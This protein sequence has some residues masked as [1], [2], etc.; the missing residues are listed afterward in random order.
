[1]WPFRR[2]Q[3]PSPKRVAEL[4]AELDDVQVTLAWLR[5]SVK[6]LNGRLSTLQRQQR[7]AA[8]PTE[9]LDV[10]PEYHED[11]S[12]PSRYPVPRPVEPTAHLARRFRE[13]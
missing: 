2:V 8:E 11:L 6:D 13:G 12:A 10:T 4:E 3:K 5:K 7:A 1:M 9:E